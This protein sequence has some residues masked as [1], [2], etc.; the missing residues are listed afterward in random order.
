MNSLKLNS[1]TEAPPDPKTAF[2]LWAASL[3]GGLSGMRGAD[4]GDGAEGNE[5]G[6]SNWLGVIIDEDEDEDS[7]REATPCRS[8]TFLEEPSP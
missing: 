6:G 3:P 4:E 8:P 7:V 2:G 1:A 5:G